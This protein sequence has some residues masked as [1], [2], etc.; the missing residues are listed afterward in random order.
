MLQHE[1]VNA[2]LKEFLTLRLLHVS[3]IFTCEHHSLGQNAVSGS[4]LRCCKWIV[5]HSKQANMFS[6]QLARLDGWLEVQCNHC[7]TYIINDWQH[8]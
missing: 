1:L 2:Y 5:L 7:C 8:Q 6:N 4:G 3:C